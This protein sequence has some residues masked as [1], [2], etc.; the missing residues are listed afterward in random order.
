MPSVEAKPYAFELDPGRIAL[1]IIDMQRDFL[2]PG[3]FGAMLGNDI[4][5]LRRTVA[6]NQRLLAAW[7]EAGLLVLHTRAGHLPDPPDL[8]P[9]KKPRGPG[10]K[11][12]AHP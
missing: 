1:L 4:A 2:E 5:Q 3:G 9:S 10:S 7:P 12:T 11:T 6:P 8:P